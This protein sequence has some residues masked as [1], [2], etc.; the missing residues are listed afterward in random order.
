MPSIL[1]QGKRFNYQSIGDKKNPCLF[2]LH[3]FLESS[4][5]W[6]DFHYL[7]SQFYL[8][9]PD[10][11]GHGQSDNH[12]SDHS[13]ERQATFLYEILKQESIDAA[14]LLGH[15]MGGYIALSFSVKYPE[16]CNEIILFH[17]HPLAD[18][19]EKK[20]Q[21]KTAI[22]LIKANK[23][24][25]CHFMISALFLKQENH[26]EAIRKLTQEAQTMSSDSI[27]ASTRGLM[28]RKDHSKTVQES[29]FKMSFI[30]GKSDPAIPEYTLFQDAISKHQVYFIADAGHMSH[31]ESPENA[32]KTIEE[33]LGFH[34]L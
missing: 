21:R 5:M 10:F 17:S 6:K 30:L 29:P 4:S 20:K 12:V 18:S 3:G 19:S 16:Y 2:L 8:I 27:I 25:Y 28:E 33:V 15:S 11:F 22:E 34:S 23:D 14:S 1:S 7:K 32:R 13:M 26:K 9:I 24:R 31:I